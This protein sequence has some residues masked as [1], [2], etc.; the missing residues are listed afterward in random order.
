MLTSIIL[1]VVNEYQVVINAPGSMR[2]RVMHC[3]HHATM[4][5]SLNQGIFIS[6]QM[7]ISDKELISDYGMH[8]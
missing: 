2:P 4:K 6:D 8:L 7:L 3:N 1:P 5:A